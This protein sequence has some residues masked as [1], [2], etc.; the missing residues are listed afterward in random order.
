MDWRMI[1]SAH[2]RNLHMKDPSVLKKTPMILML[3]GS[4]LAPLAWAQDDE[5]SEGVEMQA[6]E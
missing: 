5:A 6:D 1:E 4:S 3:L 2:F